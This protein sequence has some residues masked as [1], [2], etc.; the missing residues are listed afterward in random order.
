M[1][2]PSFSPWLVIESVNVPVATENNPRPKTRTELLLSRPKENEK[3]YH[4]RPMRQCEETRVYP[5][6]AVGGGLRLRA[7]SK[8]HSKPSPY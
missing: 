1:D 3:K 8:S 2:E 4:R 7:T 5:G 6:E